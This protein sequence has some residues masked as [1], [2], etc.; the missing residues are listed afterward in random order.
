MFQLKR[1]LGAG[2]PYFVLWR[3]FDGVRILE[4]CGLKILGCNCGCRTALR[5]NMV[6]SRSQN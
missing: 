3:G 6:S 1:D 5:V 4:H 2:M